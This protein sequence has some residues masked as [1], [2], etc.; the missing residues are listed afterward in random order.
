M[1]QTDRQTNANTNIVVKKKREKG[2]DDEQNIIKPHSIL[3]KLVVVITTDIQL[4]CV[5]KRYKGIHTKFPV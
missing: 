4:M 1:S 2:V 3:A 5:L